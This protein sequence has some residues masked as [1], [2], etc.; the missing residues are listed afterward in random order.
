MVEAGERAAEVTR[1]NRELFRYRTVRSAP[2]DI[3]GV[4]EETRTLAVQTPVRQRRARRHRL[5]ANLP[6]VRGD[7]VELQ[8]VMLNLIANA[9]DATE[10]RPA[11]RIWIRSYE[12]ADGIRVEVGDNGVGLGRVDTGRMFSLSYTTKPNGTGVGLSVSRA[13][14][15]AHG[16]RIW[17]EP[18]CRGRSDASTSRFRRVAVAKTCLR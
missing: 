4:I 9:I 6:P 1:R 12:D 14:V 10:S 8:Q 11:A 3:N 2:V 5:A 7:R 17:A 13:I 16:G 15:D 18:N